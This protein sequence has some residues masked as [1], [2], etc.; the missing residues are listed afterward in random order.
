MEV[1]VNAISF[2]LPNTKL[3]NKDINDQHP[4]WS[5]EKISLKTGIEVR[6]V[7]TV[8]ETVSEMSTK[9]GEKLFSEYVIDR[10]LIDFLIVCTQSPDYF[11]PTT[12][13]IVQSNLKLRT[14]VGAFDFNLGCSGFVYGLGIAKGLIASGSARNVLLITAETYSKFIHPDDKSNK[15]I[16]GDAA[17]AAWV[18]AD[19]IDTSF[20]IGNFVYGTDGTGAENLIVVNGAAKNPH[21]KGEDI[22]NAVEQ[23]FIR[24]DN[25]LFMNGGEIF[26]FTA[27]KVP[28]LIA[29]TLLRNQLESNNIDLYIFH[30]ANQYMLEFLRKKAN[31]PADKFYIFIKNCGNTV[32][33]TIPIALKDAIDTNRIAAGNRIM[34]AGFGVGYSWAGCVIEK[35]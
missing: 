11:L 5:I 9:V 28:L 8:D 3:T 1:Y 30:Q 32:S 33:S 29:E 20:R 17:A 23:T 35:V 19:K 10:N 24:N 21:R 27:E 4:E 6:G 25:N 13:C 26:K 31:I 2:W 18:S 12:A 14:S 16:F 15:T 7:S 34:L 22:L